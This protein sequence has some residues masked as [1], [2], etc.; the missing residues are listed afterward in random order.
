[1]AGLAAGFFRI[2]VWD[3]ASIFMLCLLPV[4]LGASG[5]ISGSETALFFLNH[6]QRLELSRSVAEIAGPGL[7]GALVQLVMAPFAILVDAASF[8]LSAFLLLRIRSSE[9]QPPPVASQVG[10]L[11]D[12]IRVGLRLVATSSPLRAIA[13]C[14]ASI[15][16]FNGLLEAVF[17]LYVTRVL[18][19]GA[20]LLGL[21]FAA[22]SVGFLA[23]ALIMDKVTVRLGLGATVTIGVAVAGVGDLLIPLLHGGMSMTLLVGLLML[24]QALFG[25]GLVVFSAGQVSIR[26][27]ATPDD[28]Q[29][30]MNATMVFI[31]GAA[32]PA[33]ALL[34]GWLGEAVG[35]R[36]ALLIAAVGEILS[37]AWLLFS[38]VR[39]LREPGAASETRLAR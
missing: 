23:G 30:R 35:L 6:H 8:L 5:F 16:L 12:Q 29:G 38:P 24:A 2:T 17:V 7:A 20:G 18:G 4:L 27:G 39:S 32:V 13:G 14:L 15:N 9:P 11:A 22:G 21:V 19:I 10:G 34:G 26:Q 1:M 37:V 33:G 36:T 25:I 3:T 28:L 31:A